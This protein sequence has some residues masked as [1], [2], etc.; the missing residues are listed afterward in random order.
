MIRDAQGYVVSFKSVETTNP[1][2]VMS[3]LK[4]TQFVSRAKPR[5]GYIVTEKAEQKSRG[6][7]AERQQKKLRAEQQQAEDRATNARLAKEENASIRKFRL[8]CPPP[9]PEPAQTGPWYDPNRSYDPASETHEERQKF[10][11]E[12]LTSVL[13]EDRIKFSL[14]RSGHLGI[15][16]AIAEHNEQMVTNSILGQRTSYL[17]QQR[18]DREEYIRQFVRE[19]AERLNTQILNDHYRIWYRERLEK[20][21]QLGPL[22]T[23]GIEML[24]LA[25]S[26]G[27]DTFSY[28]VGTLVE[29]MIKHVF[30]PADALFGE[31]SQEIALEEVGAAYLKA[32]WPMAG[33]DVL[34]SYF[35][36]E[37]DH[38]RP[39]PMRPSVWSRALRSFAR[40]STTPRRLS[41]LSLPSWSR[42]LASARPSLMVLRALALGP[43]WLLQ[44][45]SR[46]AVSRR[47]PG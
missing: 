9:P 29:V 46:S 12:K 42:R 10:I 30:E 6:I 24:D 3:S 16:P 47:C 34:H 25:L 44:L 4:H 1:Y 7:Y 15:D 18:C 26:N 33:L 35:L 14:R 45:A 27:G 31:M 43:A 32:V 28:D 22:L 17:A 13:S 23:R 21:A 5:L 20:L 37:R 40:Q 11:R 38:S 39:F 2:Q 41:T 19:D 36:N 8:R